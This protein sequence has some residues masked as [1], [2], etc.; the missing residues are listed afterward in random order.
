MKSLSYGKKFQPNAVKYK[1]LE[2][3]KKKEKVNA[4]EIKIFQTKKLLK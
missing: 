3:K 4:K 1:D 2:K